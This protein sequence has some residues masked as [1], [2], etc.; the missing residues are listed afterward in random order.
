MGI[1][2]LFL[3]VSLFP[4]FLMT[5]QIFGEGICTGDEKID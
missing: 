4:I 5:K 1:G 3:F 2:S